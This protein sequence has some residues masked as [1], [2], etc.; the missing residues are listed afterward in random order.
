MCSGCCQNHDSVT[1]LDIVFSAY[2]AP[3]SHLILKFLRG[4][5]SGGLDIPIEQA[6]RG[7]VICSKSHSKGQKTILALCA[8]IIRQGDQKRWAWWLKWADHDTDLSWDG[9]DLLG[10]QGL[11][12]YADVA[13]HSSK[14][15]LP[16]TTG[17]VGFCV[18]LLPPGRLVP[19]WND[20]LVFA[21]IHVLLICLQQ[22]GWPWMYQELNICSRLC[23]LWDTRRRLMPP[24]NR[25]FVNFPIICFVISP[26]YAPR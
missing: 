6:Q 26:H 11:K 22:M 7:P 5:C 10:A 25:G 24:L 19:A 2:K 18:H 21:T 16:E 14:E 12:V 20:P 15:I 17:W 4:A 9:L 23:A 8:N 13:F 1:Y 3:L